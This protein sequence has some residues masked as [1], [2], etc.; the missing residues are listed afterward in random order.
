MKGYKITVAFLDYYFCKDP[1]GGI[2]EIS[3]VEFTREIGWDMVRKAEYSVK[4]KY[5]TVATTLDQ[6]CIMGYSSTMTARFIPKSYEDMQENLELIKPNFVYKTG[7]RNNHNTRH[8]IKTNI[9]TQKRVHQDKHGYSRWKRDDLIAALVNFE[10]NQMS[11][12]EKTKAQIKQLQE[13]LEAKQEEI[14]KGHTIKNCTF[15]GVHW[16][17]DAVKAVET[18]ATGLKNLTELFRAQEVKMEAMLK[19]STDNTSIE[20][21]LIQQDYAE[22]KMDY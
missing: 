6:L 17:R 21:N 2:P 16:D 14:P 11:Y 1:I 10:K 4:P 9:M 12:V 22:S 19:V 5:R 3:V 13:A 20:D 18:V 8:N 7:Y 15:T